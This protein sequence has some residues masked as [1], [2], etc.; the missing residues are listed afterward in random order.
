MNRQFNTKLARRCFFGSMMLMVVFVSAVYPLLPERIVSASFN[1]M[2][3]GANAPRLTLLVSQLVFLTV[4]TLAGWAVAGILIRANP[5]FVNI[6][7]K[8]YWLSPTR[9]KATVE[10]ASAVSYWILFF[11]NLLL[12]AVFIR[13]S[14]EQIAG[15]PISGLFFPGLITLYLVGVG[16]FCLRTNKSFKTESTKNPS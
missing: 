15:I 12:W 2:G 11:T 13:I 7:N 6:P 10:K 16:G 1:L 9:R 14:V 3:S 4:Y 8:A 5:E